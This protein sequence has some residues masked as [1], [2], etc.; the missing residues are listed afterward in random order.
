MKVV[1]GHLLLSNSIYF[2]LIYVK[3]IQI[4]FGNANKT[5]IT[6]DL[7]SVFSFI[8]SLGNCKRMYRDSFRSSIEN[9]KLTMSPGKMKLKIAHIAPGSS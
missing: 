1:C 6:R 4:F 7:A 8:W 3:Q 9:F 2:T 5:L